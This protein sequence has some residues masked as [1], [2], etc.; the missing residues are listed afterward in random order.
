MNKFINLKIKK[1]L[2][3]TVDSQE[4]L[5][6]HQ[7]TVKDAAENRIV[8][9]IGEQVLRTPWAKDRIQQV[10]LELTEYY[11]KTL[12][13]VD[14]NPSLVHGA[15]QDIVKKIAT[16]TNAKIAYGI[17][18]LRQLS[19][20]RPCFFVG[21]HFGFYKLTQLSP[22]QDLNLEIALDAMNALPAFFAA[23]HPVA[24][25]LGNNSYLAA[26][27]FPGILGKIQDLAGWVTIP[28]H[29]DRGIE[30]L[31]EETSNKIQEHPNYALTILPE[32]KTSGKR[33]GG[34]PYTLEDFRTG[35]FV[36]AGMLQ[37]PI[38]PVAQFFNS[39]E[40]EGFE[41]GVFQPFTPKKPDEVE[42]PKQYFEKLAKDTQDQMQKWL[43]ERVA[44]VYP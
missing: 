36:I 23:Y 26:F 40:G 10:G 44:G 4:E 21:N 19:P 42:N 39:S 18:H 11:G 1:M 35:G 22:R 34:G 15:T 27:P 3:Q 5:I 38:V 17:E 9:L 2:E 32:G 12:K 8:N 14:S 13:L 7:R 37:L 29:N 28:F 41:I 43:N 33:N 6:Q 24:E 16:I 31:A 20:G 25:I 30:S